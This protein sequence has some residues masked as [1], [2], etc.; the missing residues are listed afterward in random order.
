MTSF[1]VSD[2]PGEATRLRSMYLDLLREVILG[3]IYRDPDE[4]AHMGRIIGTGVT[5]NSYSL[6]GQKRLQNLREL[7]ESIIKNGIPGDFIET[8][9]WQG[10]ACIWIRAILA[11]YGITDRFVYLA[12]SF[13]GV[14]EPNLAEFPADAS[15]TGLA[16]FWAVP[17]EKVKANFEAFGLLDAQ[18]QFVEGWFKDTLPNLVDSTFA[19]IRL[20]GDLYESTFQALDSL[21]PLLSPGG[22]VIIDDYGTFPACRQAVEDYRE[23]H[24]ITVP[25]QTIDLAGVWW[26]KP[27]IVRGGDDIRH[28]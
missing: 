13:R 24:S 6:V 18:V 10:G 26:R 22:F 12:D 1:S 23:K 20:D 15:L 19:L 27:K 17:M 3:T 11:T 4:K 14:P 16:K 7:V 21:Y 28:V 2:S 8:G 5:T 9:V 25:V